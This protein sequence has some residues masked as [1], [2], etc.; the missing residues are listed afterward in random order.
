VWQINLLK[1]LI[2][3]KSFGSENSKEF[4]RILDS[5]AEEKRETQNRY[6]LMTRIMTLFHYTNLRWNCRVK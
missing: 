6:F 3:I 5:E 2:P 1:L 4:K